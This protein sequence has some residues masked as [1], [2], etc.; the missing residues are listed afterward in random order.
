VSAK[1]SSLIVSSAIYRVGFTL[2]L[3]SVG[4]GD[5]TLPA[6]TPQ[7]I[8]KASDAKEQA[9]LIAGQKCRYHGYKDLGIDDYG[10][11]QFDCDRGMYTLELGQSHLFDQQFYSFKTDDEVRFRF[12]DKLL[13]KPQYV[14]EAKPQDANPAY[15]LEPIR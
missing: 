1:P 15:Y 5:V 6:I 10:A 12:S 13:M 2:L 3:A 9:R 8:D 4:C 7:K 11:Q 14:G